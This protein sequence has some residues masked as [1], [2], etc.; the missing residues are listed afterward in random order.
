[1]VLG[2]GGSPGGVFIR[3]ALSAIED[4]TGFVPAMS[5]TVIGTSVGALNAARIDSDPVETPAAVVQR[6]EVLAAHIPPPDL[7]VLDRA[8][9][10]PRQIVGRAVGRFVPAGTNRPDYPVA[11]GPYHRAVRTVSCRRSDGTRR[12]ANLSR[13]VAPA[14]ELYASAA[15][16]GFAPP[17]VLDGVEHVDGAV[18]STTNADLVSP[19]DH[20][21]L[22]VIAPMASRSG[23][24]LL[25]RS[26]RAAVVAELA[27][28]KRLGKPALFIAPSA[29]A[30]EGRH[31]HDAFAADAE[32][33]ILG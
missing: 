21:G 11:A 20:D 22:I 8:L 12:I 9:A 31:D 7:G 4:R 26:H 14:A 5:S 25:P 33:R 29:E 32:A 2:A 17:V 1:M 10:G 30:I 15:I 27:P 18:W 19:D 3:A 16:P 6:L 24:G 13:A 23:G 28:W